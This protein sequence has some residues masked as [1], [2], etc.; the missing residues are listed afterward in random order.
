M[1]L[2]GGGDRGV[3]DEEAARLLVR[4][5]HQKKIFTH[6]GVASTTSG[7]VVTWQGADPIT[8]MRPF[9]RTPAGHVR[10]STKMHQPRTMQTG[11]VSAAK[12]SARRKP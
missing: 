8:P 4:H 5:L 9:R 1:G 3:S 7:S 2:V 6:G 12:R 10:K 11:G